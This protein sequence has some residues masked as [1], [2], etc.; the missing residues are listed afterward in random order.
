MWLTFLVIFQPQDT[1]LKENVEE[2][3]PYYN[4]ADTKDSIVETKLE[5]KTGPGWFHCKNIATKAQSRSFDRNARNP[6]HAGGEFAAY[7]EL[8]ALT[9]HFHPT[10]ALFARNI[11]ESKQL[12]VICKQLQRNICN[13]NSSN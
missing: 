9:S 13:V 6:A 1:S 11:L 5:N 8:V 12:S 7:E 10:V 2:E 4:N 3:A